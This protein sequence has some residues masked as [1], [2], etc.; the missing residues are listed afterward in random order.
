MKKFR[1]VKLF[2]FVLI[3]NLLLWL[4]QG[5]NNS[6][7]LVGEQIAEH[8]QNY[9]ISIER[10]TISNTIR[11][12]EL[13]SYYTVHSDLNESQQQKL[14]STIQSNGI[15][16]ERMGTIEEPDGSNPEYGFYIISGIPLY[17]KVTTKLLVGSGSTM[18]EGYY[19]FIFGWHKVFIHLTGIS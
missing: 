7:I 18:H 6:I 19:I 3:A 15:I 2:L 8:Q 12:D 13:P 4:F 17:S 11:G 14:I 10:V 9:T 16:V 1:T 5:K